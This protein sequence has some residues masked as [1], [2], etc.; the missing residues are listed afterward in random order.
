LSGVRQQTLLRTTVR[1]L[2]ALSSS[3]IAF[4]VPLLV[5]QMT[6]SATTAGMSF[7]IEWL[8]R[9]ASIGLAAPWVDRI[10]GRAA[11]GAASTLRI[12]SIVVVTSIGIGASWPVLTALAAANGVLAQVGSAGTASL[13]ADAA[14]SADRD[15]SRRIQVLQATVDQGVLLVGPLLAAL[16]AAGGT[17]AVLWPTAGLAAGAVMAS[18]R[19][20]RRR[21][22]RSLQRR[23]RPGLR[24][25]VQVMRACPA[26]MWATTAALGA[27]MLA[28]VVEAGTPIEVVQTYHRS[29]AATGGLWTAAAVTAMA[30]MPVISRAVRRWGTWRTSCASSA[31]TAGAAVLAGLACGYTLYVVAI[32]GVS[33]AEQGIGLLLAGARTRLIPADRYAST[34]ALGTLAILL[35][36]PLAGLAIGAAGRTALPGIFLTC[37]ALAAA[38]AGLSLYRLHGHRTVLEGLAAGPPPA[39]ALL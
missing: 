22:R 17:R 13:A 26:L 1:A 4:G 38:T 32:A 6:G 16:L 11:V 15:A 2:D 29:P 37:G 33:A 23:Q 28:A 36:F 10:G 12:A 7:A 30:A 8:P 31:I 5:L 19:L 20:P 3:L 24:S 25:G 14:R 9:L 18:G 27:N 34:A 39:P 35:P 21:T